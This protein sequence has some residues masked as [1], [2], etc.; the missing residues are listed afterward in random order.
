[1]NWKLLNTLVIKLIVAENLSGAKLW[2]IKKKTPNHNSGIMEIFSK[3][4]KKIEQKVDILLECVYVYF[5]CN[6]NV[7][8][9]RVNIL[10][11]V[12]VKMYLRFQN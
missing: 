3:T 7:Y 5:I 8:C 4:S 6:F 2:K 12:M 11:G 9:P 1:M 10:C